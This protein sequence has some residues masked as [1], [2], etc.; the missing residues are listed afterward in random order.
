MTYT[1]PDTSG[2]ERA[3]NDLTEPLY[4]GSIGS[5]R[6]FHV[7]RTTAGLINNPRWDLFIINVYTL[8]RNAYS[9]D[10]KQQAIEKIV[11]ADVDL[12]MTFIGAY[13]SFLRLMPATVLFY[14]PNYRA[15]PKEL[16]R[17]TTGQRAEMDVMYDKLLHK[18]PTKLTE[19]TEDVSVRKFLVATSGNTFP[20]KELPGYIREIYGGIRTSGQIG[21][22]L[23]THCPIDLHLTT[24]IPKMDLFES[25]TGAIYP[26]S[27]FG[28][29]L[30]KEVKVPFNTTTHRAFGDD[31]HLIALCKGPQK[32][33]LVEL[34][35]KRNWTIHTEREIINDITSTFSDISSSE[36]T[37]LRL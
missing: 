20:H 14:A 31:I 21:T 5:N 17:K 12:Y 22:V 24:T 15:I 6:I 4:R 2:L 10:I 34:A 35:A 37:R 32:T 16:L 11:D 29:K 23:F 13:C 33:K 9:K 27:E 30:T 18:L 1:F 28:R 36:L 3:Q 26:V 7:L 25:F 8:L 19:L